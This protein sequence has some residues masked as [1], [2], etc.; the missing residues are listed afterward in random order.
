[1]RRGE[2]YIG[3]GESDFGKVRPF[4]IVQANELIT[5]ATESY[6]ACPTTTDI[7][8]HSFRVLLPADVATGLTA[9]SEVMV[10]KV[11]PL[12][13]HR[14]RGRIGHCS[15]EQMRMLEG[16]LAFVLGLRG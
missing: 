16:R 10:E 12:K 13:V 2:I 14:L 9:A 8:N 1:M 6:L 11:G 7:Q 15:D 4:V 3:I 5:G